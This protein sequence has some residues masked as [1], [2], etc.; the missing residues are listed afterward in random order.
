MCYVLD[1]NGFVILSNEE[2]DCGKFIADVK[3]D[4]IVDVVENLVKDGI[5][6]RTRF[7]DYQAICFY[8]PK[9]ESHAKKTNSVSEHFIRSH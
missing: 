6:Q 7:F 5:Y 3:V 8:D 4:N 2:R 9:T 1:D